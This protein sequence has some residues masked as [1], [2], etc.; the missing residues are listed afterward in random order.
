MP[1]VEL[2][3]AIEVVVDALLFEPTEEAPFG[4]G[5]MAALASGNGVG[6]AL[7][8]VDVVVGVG[9]LERE[10]GVVVGVIGAVLAFGIA[11]EFEARVDSG[12]GR[13]AVGVDVVGA[14]AEAVVG[15]P[16]DVGGEYG[17]FAGRFFGGD[18][19]GEGEEAAG[20]VA[21]VEVVEPRSLR[22]GDDLPHGLAVVAVLVPLGAYLSVIAVGGDLHI[23]A[24]AMLVEGADTADEFLVGAVAPQLE[25]VFDHG[26]N[27]ELGALAAFDAS[28]PH[29]AEQAVGEQ[30]EVI[31]LVGVGLHLDDLGA[32]AGAA[33]DDFVGA[34]LDIG[35]DRA[36]DGRAGRGDAAGAAEFEEDVG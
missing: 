8:L 36:G 27:A 14:A 17:E 6:Q 34:G 9:A 25:A 21:G 29:I 7:V 10:R 13:E 20:L 19:P 30:A 15:V 1:E 2:G 3:L 32:V 28:G 5:H 12:G 22:G 35:V 33:E 31:G 4:R 16:V 23:G 24:R 26:V 11:L 18:D